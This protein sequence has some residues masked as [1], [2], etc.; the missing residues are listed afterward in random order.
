MS[1]YEARARQGREECLKKIRE[2]DRKISAIYREATKEMGAKAAGAKEGS[3]TKRWA[4][5]MQKSLTESSRRLGRDV[6]SEITSA[7]QEAAA[8]PGRVDRDWLR[9]AYAG[10]GGNLTG[11]TF[12]NMFTRTS[13]EALRMLLS[14]RAYLDG[15]S[16]SSRVWTQTGRLENGINQV[17]QQGIAQKKSAVQIA[18]ELEQYVNPDAHETIAQRRE[19]VKSGAKLPFAGSIEYNCQR[20]ARTSV[21]H[22]YFLAM[23]E[24]AKLNPFCR[25]VHWEL[26]GAHFE[27]QV[28]PFGV[29]ICDEYA[30]HDEGLGVGNWPVD[31]TPLPHAQCLCSQWPEVPETLDECAGRLK[32]WLAGG[33]DAALDASYAAWKEALQSGMPDKRL[34]SI[35]DDAGEVRKGLLEKIAGREDV[36]ALSVADRTRLDERLM[37]YSEDDIKKLAMGK[38]KIYTGLERKTKNTGEYAA[39]EEPMQNRHLDAVIKDT[40]VDYTGIET[41]IER[42]PELIGRQIYGYTSP[43]GKRVTFYPDAFTNIRELVITIG[44]ERCHVR[45]IENSGLP[46]DSETALRYEKEAEEEGINIWKEYSKQKGIRDK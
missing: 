19:R 40:G 42:D 34:G 6:L 7:V 8:I 1:E 5:D 36:Q 31:S 30:T 43:D 9:D 22:A 24:S 15:K 41:K 14:G 11:Q 27:R 26:S 32:S 35:R 10:A 25:A 38:K 23:K 33:E 37:D 13:D 20:V 39:L 45:Q 28:M 4:L 21:N 29:D 18:R 2:T 46:M 16:L 17:I 3:L 44:H 12:H